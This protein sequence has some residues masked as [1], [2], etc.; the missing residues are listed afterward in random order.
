[1]VI[2]PSRIGLIGDVHAEDEALE[3]ALRVFADAGVD[4]VMA[5]GDIVDR[6]AHTSVYVDIVASAAS[7][8]GSTWVGSHPRLDMRASRGVP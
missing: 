3:L 2:A 1:V 7:P 8:E 6:E 5:V 4:V